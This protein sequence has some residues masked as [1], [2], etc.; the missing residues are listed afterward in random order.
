MTSLDNTEQLQLELNQ[1]IYQDLRE[2]L[3]ATGQVVENVQAFNLVL[4]AVATNLG[5]M[6]A[7]V[8]DAYRHIFIQLTNEIISQSLTDTLKTVDNIHWGYIGHA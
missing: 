5:A 2:Y 4:N 3:N 1:Q 8:P 6:L 7:Q